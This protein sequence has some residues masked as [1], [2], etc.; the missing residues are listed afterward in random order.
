MA[1][2]TINLIYSLAAIG[3]MLEKSQKRSAYRIPTQWVDIPAT[4]RAGDQPIAVRLVDISH[5]GAGMQA[6]QGLSLNES[7]SLN[8]A[9]PAWGGTTVDI[10]ARLV[11]SRNTPAGSGN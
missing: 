8:V 6:D 2:A 11:R 4:L 10:P 9:V 1:L 5:S 3:I 7:I